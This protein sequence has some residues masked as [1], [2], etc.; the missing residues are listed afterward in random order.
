M[1]KKPYL[2]SRFLFLG[3]KVGCRNTGFQTDPIFRVFIGS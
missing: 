2:Q 1:P 3:R